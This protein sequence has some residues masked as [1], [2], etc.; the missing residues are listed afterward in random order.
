MKTAQILSIGTALFAMFFGAGNVIFPLDLGRLL[1]DKVFYAIPGLFISGVMMPIIGVYAGVL[2]KGDYRA[3]FHKIG[4]IPGE[5]LILIC[6]LTIGPLGA[7]PRTL[8]LAHA[9]FA[10]YFP[11]LPMGLF[12]IAAGLVILFFTI[13]ESKV[14]SFIGKVLA[15]IKIALLSLIILCGL[16]LAQPLAHSDISSAESFFRGLYQGYDTLDL[17]VAL[18]FARL[19]YVGLDAETLSH[20]N[21]VRIGL[22]KAS[23][24]G[25][26]LLGLIYS[27]FMLTS[28]FHADQIPDVGRAKLVFALGD[29]LL[30]KLG[31]IASFTVAFATLTT[32]IALTAVFADYLSKDILRGYLTYGM[33][34]FLSVIVTCGLAML[35]FEGVAKIITPVA[36][37]CYPALIVLAITGILNKLYGFE[38][39][40]LPVFITLATTLLVTFVI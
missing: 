39:I 34:V 24:F 10:W 1:D 2:F 23:A 26:V 9:G 18:F 28:A 30:G 20:P 33:S 35:G 22:L 14:L 29:L 11:S 5:L 31:L 17:L 13:K 40:K 32:A 6:M 12:I 3:L 37:I 36:V 7:I 38:H 15:P 16:W 4:A 8:T 25:A 19:I 21:S 27:G